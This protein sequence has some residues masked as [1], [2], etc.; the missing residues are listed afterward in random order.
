VIALLGATGTIGRHIAA[1]LADRPADARAVVRDPSRSDV[2]LPLVHGDLTRPQTLRAAFEGAE[3]LLLLAPHGPEQD[4]QEAA[5][6]EAAVAAGVQQIV[7]IS[8]GPPRSGPTVP[9]RPRWD[10]GAPSD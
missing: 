10:T 9:H 8:G 2:P 3:R 7:K 1:G 4:L 5:A 6:V